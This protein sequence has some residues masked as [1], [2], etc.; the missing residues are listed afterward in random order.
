LVSLGPPESPL[1][2]EQPTLRGV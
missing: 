2:R 1:Q